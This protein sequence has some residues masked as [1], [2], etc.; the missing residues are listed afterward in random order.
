MKGITGYV[1]GR[2]FLV[3][4]FDAFW[5]GVGI[6]FERIVRPVLVVV[7]AI[8]SIATI[9]LVSGVPRQFWVMWQNIRCSI[10]FHLEVPGG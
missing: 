3:G 9:T 2:H 10:L 7:F 5:I 4:D 8:S 1:E 6:E